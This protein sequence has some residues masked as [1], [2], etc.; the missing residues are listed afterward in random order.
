MRAAGCVNFLSATSTEGVPKLTSPLGE[1]PPIASSVRQKYLH[2]PD[3][4]AA[5][6]NNSP[7]CHVPKRN[8][9]P[10]RR[11]RLPYFS[12]AQVE[13]GADRDFTSPR[14]FHLPATSIGSGLPVRRGQMLWGRVL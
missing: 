2:M 6:P 5:A 10:A 12:E 9:C 8:R 1:P 3:R 13:V 11:G 14:L 7:S 4:F